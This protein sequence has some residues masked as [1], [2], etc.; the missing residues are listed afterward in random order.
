M[1]LAIRKIE[2]WAKKWRMELNADTLAREARYKHQAAA[3]VDY[4]TV[5]SR[6]ERGSVGTDPQK[7]KLRQLP[8]SSTMVSNREG[9]LYAHL[10]TSPELMTES[11]EK[12]S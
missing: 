11:G 1:Q 8:S 3:A 2:Q 12:H 6:Q 10:Q 9:H 4:K 7:N 5:K